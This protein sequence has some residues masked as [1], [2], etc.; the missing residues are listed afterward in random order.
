[1]GSWEWVLGLLGWLRRLWVWSICEMGKVKLGSRK[2]KDK[3]RGNFDTS[4]SEM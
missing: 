2:D 4:A 1:M 3:E